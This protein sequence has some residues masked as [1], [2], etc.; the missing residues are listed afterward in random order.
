MSG[1]KRR[2]WLSLK[3]PMSWA[4][5]TG[6]ARRRL[7]STPTFFILSFNRAGFFKNPLVGKNEQFLRRPVSQLPDNPLELE[8]E[9][10]QILFGDGEGAVDLGPVLGVGAEERGRD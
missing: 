3:A 8:D 5:T 2:T 6:R 10:S 4:R 9:P 7:T 1:R